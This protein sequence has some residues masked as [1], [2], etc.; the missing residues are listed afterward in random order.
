MSEN[1]IIYETH[2]GFVP[3]TDEKQIKILELLAEK[4]L[5]FNNISSSPGISFNPA[6][7][8]S[9][10][11][12]SGIIN[13]NDSNDY[14][15]IGKIILNSKSANKCDN[16]EYNTLTE[17][18][19]NMLSYIF[20]D[21]CDAYGFHKNTF[22]DSYARILAEITKNKLT[23]NSVESVVELFN[24]MCKP[25]KVRIKSHEPL[26]IDVE[27]CYKND[28]S[29]M[30]SINVLKHWMEHI[31]GT[32]YEI[33][34]K[35]NCSNNLVSVTFESR[36]NLHNTTPT[37][38]KKADCP[39]AITI[40]DSECRIIS[41]PVQVKIVDRIVEKLATR[42]TI[43]DEIDACYTTINTNLKK[44]SDSGLIFSIDAGGLSYCFPVH[45]TMIFAG[46]GELNI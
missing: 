5:S 13:K 45:N 7:S 6:Y 3:V 1:F 25:F 26:S 22:L 33:V 17:I 31:H 21:F 39:F 24:S 9:K 46:G 4:S 19:R 23:G 30:V 38:N 37:E 20:L 12:K 28:E 2:N 34:N 40:T 29:S 36:D 44:M 11:Q 27:K 35:V 15:I 8:I 43:I 10:L 14:Q 42:N 41:H 18:N 32:K 16:Y